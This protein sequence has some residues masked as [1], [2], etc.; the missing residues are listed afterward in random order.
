MRCRSPRGSNLISN[1]GG[2]NL[3][4]KTA[5]PPLKT[6]PL[7]GDATADLVVIGG[8]FTGCSAALHVARQGANVRL[9]E[10]KI[11]GFGGSGRNV[12]LVN[13][14]LWMPPGDVEAKLGAKAGAKLNDTLAKAPDLVFS[15][16]ERH[17]IECEAV[18]SGTLHCAHSADGLKDL[19]NRYRQQTACNAPV[20]LLD[21]AETARITGAKIFKGGLLDPRAGTIQPFAYCRGLAAAAFHAGAQIHELTPAAQIAR[22]GADWLVRTTTGTVRAPALLLATNG[23]HEEAAGIPAPTYVPVNYFQAA[24][25]P[26]SANLRNTILPG[27]QGCWDTATI[28]SSFRMDADGRLIVGGMGA[29]DHPASEAHKSWAARKI[30]TLFP[31]IGDQPLEYFWF[32][33]IAMTSDHLPKIVRLGARGF[34]IFGYSG[35]GIAPGTAFGK[36]AAEVLLG[37]SEDLL[38]VA[39]V[40]RHSEWLTGAKALFYEAGATAAHFLNR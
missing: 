8:G 14:G 12:G 21:A 3:W 16:I 30:A 25:H 32:G 20:K 23:Y 10:A 6:R 4:W 13:A 33:R 26:L 40:E 7:G 29:L 18:R 1:G 31:H 19:A 39:P 28:M 34:S 11:I 17:A 2:K 36:A 5:G 27:R 38:P 24:T 15:L 35:R 37:G 9:L 22:S